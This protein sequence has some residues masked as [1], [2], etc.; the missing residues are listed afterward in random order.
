MAFEYFLK[1]DNASAKFVIRRS[2]FDRY[3]DESRYVI[4]R[5]ASAE[6]DTVAFTNAVVLHLAD[7][8]GNFRNG[9]A[10]YLADFRCGHL[11]VA[12]QYFQNMLVNMIHVSTALCEKFRYSVV[13]ILYYG[14]K[15]NMKCEIHI[16][17]IFSL[18][19]DLFTIVKIAVHIGK[20]T[21]KPVTDIYSSVC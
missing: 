13:I 7:T 21:P 20:M 16:F 17:F 4:A 9:Q 6:L 10:Y 1:G 5:L 2:P 18:L 3:H 15:V 8:F 19:P 14:K 12:F 11:T